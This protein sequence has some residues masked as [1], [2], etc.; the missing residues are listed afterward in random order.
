MLQGWKEIADYVSRDER[1]VKRWEKQRQLPVRRM[2]GA[3]RTNVY[4]LVAELEEW[5][6]H[7]PVPAAAEAPAATR[8]PPAPARI[9]PLPAAFAAM[10]LA[11]AATLLTVRA[12]H[13]HT[14]PT[15]TTPYASHVPGVD[16][17][18]LRGVY[19]YEQHTP[20]ALTQSRQYLQQAVAKDPADAPAWATLASTTLMLEQFE[21][22]P[23]AQG[24]DEAGTAARHALTLDPTLADAHATLA[25][26]DFYWLRDR[27]AAE[28][29][30]RTA[31]TLDPNSGTAHHRYGL[32]LLDLRRFPEALAE[33]DTALRLQPSSTVI[34]ATRALALGFNGHRDDA[35][36]TLQSLAA[37]QPQNP[38]IYKDLS[39]LAAMQPHNMPLFLASFKSLQQIEHQSPPWQAAAARAYSAGGEPAV[40]QAIVHA[41]GS[42]PIEST[43][44]AGALVQL[45]QN[46]AALDILERSARH[47]GDGMSGLAL[48]PLLDPLHREPRFQALLGRLGLAPLP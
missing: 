34:V 42:A 31:L 14:Q 38:I 29:E 41:E 11:T 37:Q 10:V 28:Q 45:G 24:F 20:A 46:G 4:V 7:S 8:L 43:L 25:F 47:P 21:V 27:V 9:W 2:P 19:F 17:L 12:H 18:Y 16:D 36:A 3:G 32:M 40:W 6:N 48:D 1:T 22:L 23:T 44:R 33:L 30:F 26:V 13:V 35:V 39:M 15:A 5:L